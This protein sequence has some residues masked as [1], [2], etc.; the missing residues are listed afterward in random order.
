MAAIATRRCPDSQPDWPNS[1]CWAL[2]TTQAF[3]RDAIRHPIFAGGQATTRFI[4]KAFTRWLDAGRRHAAPPAGR[5]LREL[6]G[7]ADD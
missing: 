3:L 5:G 2:P 1:P 6:G 7:T 4:E